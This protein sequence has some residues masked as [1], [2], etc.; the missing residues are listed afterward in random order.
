MKYIIDLIQ[1][2]REEINN[3]SNYDVKAMLLKESEDTPEQ[4]IN[5]GESPLNGFNID[6]NSSTL[7]FYIDGSNSQ[8]ITGDILKE[9]L[10][11]DMG[12][13]MYEL[14]IDINIDHKD[15]DVIGFGKATNESSYFL[16]IK[17]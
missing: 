2:I 9:I 14:K 13:L 11:L 6:Q 4:L 1:D 12:S 7:K 15:I 3:N 10:I 5:V 8:L 17:I 16:F